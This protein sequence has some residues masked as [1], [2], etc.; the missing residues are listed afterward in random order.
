MPELPDLVYIEKVLRSELGCGDRVDSA[1]AGAG[2][3]TGSGALSDADGQ[4]GSCGPAIRE[5]RVKEP[6]VVRMV[7]PGSFTEAL[8]GKRITDIRRHGPFLRIALGGAEEASL[9]M[10]IHFMLAGKLHL[11]P[12]GRRNPPKTCF[13]LVLD[14]GSALHYA[15]AR[16]MGKVYVVPA[17]EYGAVPGYL[18]QGVDVTAPDFTREAFRALVGKRRHQVRVFLMD[19]KAL[20]A[21]GNAYADEILF[22]ARIHPKTLC[23][24]L[25]PEDVERLYESILRVMGRAIREVEAAGR[26]I[27]EKIRDHVRVRNRR[28]EPCPRCGAVIRRTSVLG[29]DSFFCPRCQPAT[30]KTLVPWDELST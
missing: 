5:V 26:P 1:G 14:S 20:S 6:I 10:V 30:R 8:V 7:A 21:I 24:R 25:R 17:G 12:E 19:Q 13:A 3:P 28:G 22:E 2:G 29:Y 18:E 9:D 4:P 23:S 11:L 16:K 27:D 15:D